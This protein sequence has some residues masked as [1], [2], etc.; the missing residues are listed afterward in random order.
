MRPG[1]PGRMT[2]V[3][4]LDQ[5]PFMVYGPCGPVSMVYGPP[6]DQGPQGLPWRPAGLF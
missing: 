1:K 5:H 6:I 2:F 3:H 4:I